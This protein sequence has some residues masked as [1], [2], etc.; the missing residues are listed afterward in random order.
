MI[1]KQKSR[2][3]ACLRDTHGLYLGDISCPE[4][5][6]AETKERLQSLAQEYTDI[7]NE[8]FNEMDKDG[9]GTIRVC[10]INMQPYSFE[11]AA[12]VRLFS[13]SYVF[14]IPRISYSM[15]L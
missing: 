5:M 9:G 11:R 13:R 6:D 10:A 15:K 3:R 1:K 7:V 14:M 2:N 4:G 8:M 12:R